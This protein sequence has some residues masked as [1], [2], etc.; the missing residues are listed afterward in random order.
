MMA[1]VKDYFLRRWVRSFWKAVDTETVSLFQTLFY[2]LLISAG[3]YGLLIAGEVPQIVEETMSPTYYTLWLILNVLG[4]LA[5]LIGK[6]LKGEYAYAGYILQLAGDVGA[7]A[8]IG[9]YVAATL[10]TSWWGK[11]IYA[12]FIVLMG[13]LGTILFIAR[14]IRRLRRIESIR[15][16]GEEL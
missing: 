14:D 16:M 7:A 3:V 1:R 11:G 8:A 9:T 10:A 12:L 5:C 15:A 13:L 2:T 4:P 6:R